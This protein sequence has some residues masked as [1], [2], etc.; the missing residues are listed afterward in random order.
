MKWQ[1]SDYKSP[2]QHWAPPELV[3]SCSPREKDALRALKSVFDPLPPY[4]EMEAQAITQNEIVTLDIPLPQGHIAFLENTAEQCT[5]PQTKHSRQGMQGARYWVQRVDTAEGLYRRLIDGYGISLMF[6]ER[7][8][9]FI[10]NSNNWRGS[11]GWLLDIDD[12][13]KPV[14]PGS[15]EEH[16]EYHLPALGMPAEIKE[17]MR[18]DEKQFH[19]NWTDW[20]TDIQA[21]LDVEARVAT[22]VLN[23]Y[24]KPDP[25]YSPDE[26][27][28][29]ARSF[30]CAWRN[31]ALFPIPAL[32][33]FGVAGM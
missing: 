32:W 14:A 29:A 12:W 22:A 5:S 1:A 6:G 23:N 30:A 24:L 8:H 25:C 3:Y 20:V 10:R 4:K 33:L 28:E 11:S 15:V 18:R 7:C 27:N 19:K 31:R 17:M 16:V 26:L 13:R 9:Q 21:L 2:F